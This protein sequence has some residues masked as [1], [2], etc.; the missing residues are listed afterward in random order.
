M[1]SVSVGQ[2]FWSSEGANTA[3]VRQFDVLRQALPL[4]FRLV[5]SASGEGWSA[6]EFF[7]SLEPVLFF[8]TGCKSAAFCAVVCR[9]GKVPLP[10]GGVWS[11][12]GRRTRLRLGVPA[13][14]VNRVK[15]PI[16]VSSLSV[17]PC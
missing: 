4:Y 13:T 1:T 11:R 9:F 16:H 2:T 12:L 15:R 17:K 8:V 6:T 7:F 10:I 5:V 3:G 14:L